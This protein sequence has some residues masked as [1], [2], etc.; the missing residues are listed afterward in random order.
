VTKFTISV[1]SS[2]CPEGVWQPPAPGEATGA[3]NGLQWLP[4]PVLSSLSGVYAASNSSPV[5]FV[6]SFLSQSYS[7]T[8]SAGSFAL[9]GTT[10]FTWASAPPPFGPG[11]YQVDATLLIVSNYP[12]T[13]TILGS[14]S[15]PQLA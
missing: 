3:Y 10:P 1:T 12:I 14:Y 8:A 5:W 11:D 6:I 13:V 4:L 15:S 7:S 9:T 2:S